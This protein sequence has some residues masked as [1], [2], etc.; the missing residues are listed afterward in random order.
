M[1]GHGSVERQPAIPFERVGIT[2]YAWDGHT[3]DYRMK[4]HD[5]NV[6]IVDR[7][8]IIPDMRPGAASPGRTVP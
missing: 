1:A 5:S 7:K 4:D 8:G 6:M 2:L 3:K